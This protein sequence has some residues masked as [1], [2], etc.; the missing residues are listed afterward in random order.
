MTV[1]LNK[2]EVKKQ[3]PSVTKKEAKELRKIN[4]RPAKEQRKAAKRNEKIIRQ[5]GNL[6]VLLE[7]IVEAE[8]NIKF[9]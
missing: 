3:V 4:P 7:R 2:R 1:V 5:L 6:P 8:I 9:Y